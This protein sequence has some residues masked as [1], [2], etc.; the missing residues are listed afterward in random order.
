MLLLINCYKII[1]LIISISA[2]K[3]QRPLENWETSESTSVSEFHQFL[4][5][6]FFVEEL[7]FST[8]VLLVRAAC[9]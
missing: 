8:F 6:N 5:G 7:D 9:G 3:Y 4:E 2:M 1:L